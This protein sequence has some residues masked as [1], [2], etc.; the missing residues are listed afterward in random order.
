MY[1]RIEVALRPEFPDPASKRFLRQLELALPEIRKDITWARQLDVYWI[2]FE[3]EVGREFL[4]PAVTEI[5]WDRVLCWLF[6]GDLIPSAAGRHGNLVDLFEVAS[7]R[8]GKF[9]GLER[10]F[11]GG[12]TDSAARSVIEAFEIMLGRPLP[13]AM[14]ATGKLLL[15]RKS[16]V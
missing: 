12:V 9:W 1:A 13:T 15:D 4:I 3:A 14:A 6:S 10:R 11:R 16:V 5:F 8:S 2:G 7:S